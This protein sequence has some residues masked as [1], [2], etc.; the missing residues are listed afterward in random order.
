MERD[1][2]NV[3]TGVSNAETLLFKGTVN[4][5]I[6]YASLRFMVSEADTLE[7]H[8]NRA[9]L[10]DVYLQLKCTECFPFL[11]Y[12]SSAIAIVCYRRC[13]VCS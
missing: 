13:K 12:V 7:I 9:Y 1:N 10:T 6:P 11:L 3:F 4:V 2:A 5:S 8:V